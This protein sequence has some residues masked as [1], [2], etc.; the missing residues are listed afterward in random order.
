MD[1][2]LQGVQTRAYNIARL[3]TGNQDEALD[4]VQD[5]M[6]K[7]V[8]KYS[9]RPEP[10]WSPLFYRILSSRINDW[11]RRSSVRNRF[12]R[13]LSSDPEADEDPIQTAVDEFG[14]RPDRDTETSQSMTRLEQA[15]AALPARQKQAFLLRAWEGLDVKQT[16]LAMSCAEGSVKTHYSRAVHMLREQLGDH[17]P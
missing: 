12:R 9:D 5:A 8:E 14:Q 17:W 2:F 11:H 3:A 13:W 7:L 1:R 4:I 6:F 10:E 15:L 16:A